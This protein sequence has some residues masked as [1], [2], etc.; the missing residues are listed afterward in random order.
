[1]FSGAVCCV[2]TVALTAFVMDNVAQTAHRVVIGKQF[3]IA[4]VA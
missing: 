2:C 3:K 4:A 1:V